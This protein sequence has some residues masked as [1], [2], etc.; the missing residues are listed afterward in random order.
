MAA[1]R[2]T[3]EIHTSPHIA[4]GASVDNIMRNVVIALLPVCAFAAL[5]LFCTHAG[6]E[7]EDRTSSQA[8]AATFPD[9]ETRPE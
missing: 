2:T 6:A 3:L 5:T 8:A 9:V 1:P 4:S 7:P